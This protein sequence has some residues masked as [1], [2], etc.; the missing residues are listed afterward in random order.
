M[1]RAAFL[2][3]NKTIKKNRTKTCKKCGTVTTGREKTCAVGTAKN[4]C[5]GVFDEVI[6]P[7]VNLQYIHDEIPQDFIDATIEKFNLTLEGI[8][9][10]EFQKN[11]AGCDRY[12]GR[13]CPYKKYCESGCMTGLYKKEA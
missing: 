3:L 1:E 13:E 11:L 9:S 4:R 2:V 8:K 6:D 5:H 10:G 7:Q 12:Y